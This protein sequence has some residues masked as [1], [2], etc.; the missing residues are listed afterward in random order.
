MNQSSD[1]FYVGL[2]KHKV[3]KQSHNR[4]ATYITFE[5]V[6]GT[7]RMNRRAD[8]NYTINSSFDEVIVHIGQ[9]GDIG[10]QGPA[11]L[12]GSTGYCPET[13]CPSIDMSSLKV[14]C[15]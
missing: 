1:D 15:Y 5:E 13:I 14:S 8:Y 9:K 7:Y 3:E 6:S 10:P 4:H 12:V 11:G 2:V